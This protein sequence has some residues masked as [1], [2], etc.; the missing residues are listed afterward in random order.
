[1][2]Q[3]LRTAQT[4]AVALFSSNPVNHTIRA[5]P[6]RPSNRIRFS[7]RAVETA[8]QGTCSSTKTA[9]HRASGRATQRG[10][11]T[12]A[13]TRRQP[14]STSAQRVRKPPQG[15]MTAVPGKYCRTALAPSAEGRTGPIEAYRHGAPL[16]ISRHRHALFERTG[17][18]RSG[19]RRLVNQS[20]RMDD[21]E[22]YIDTANRRALRS[23]TAASRARSFDTTTG[24]RSACGAAKRAGYAHAYE[25]SEAAIRRA[26]ANRA[27]L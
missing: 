11:Y 21:G 4:R 23:M 8:N 1:M 7:E 19:S 22:L 18:D 26:A 15:E 27:S 3:A 12:I 17:M 14:H 20:V 25:L 10:N 9:V 13:R 5:V 24:V 2:G 6:H 16:T